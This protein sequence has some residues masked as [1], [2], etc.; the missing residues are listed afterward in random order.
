MLLTNSEIS[1]A[2]RISVLSTLADI[3]DDVDEN[4]DINKYIESI[5]YTSVASIIRKCETMK[6]SPFHNRCASDNFGASVA[7]GNG[8]NV[9]NAGSKVS[10][11]SSAEKKR[12]THEQLL[13]LKLKRQCHICHSYGPWHKTIMRTAV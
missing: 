3:I 2:E 11:Y 13:D 8:R 9:H 12:L 6:T 10:R 4:A 1:D 5:K 7:Y